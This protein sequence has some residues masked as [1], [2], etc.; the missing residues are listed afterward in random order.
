[1]C[2]ILADTLPKEFTHK[3]KATKNYLSYIRGKSS[4]S[5]A[6]DKEKAT[7]LDLYTNNNISESVF[8]RLTEAIIKSSMI[9]LLYTEVIYQTRYNGDFSRNL[10]YAKKKKIN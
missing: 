9:S 5:K 7:G 8:G 10:L 6:I 4:Q 1:M 2:F 3:R